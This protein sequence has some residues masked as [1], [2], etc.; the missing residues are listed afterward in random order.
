MIFVIQD[1]TK[2]TCTALQNAASVA[3]TI[4][5]TECVVVDHPKQ[6]ETPQQPMY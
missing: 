1:P 2:V 6:E 4:L 5:L 3:G